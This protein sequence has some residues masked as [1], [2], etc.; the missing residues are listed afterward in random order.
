MSAQGF[1]GSPASVDV[2]RQ[3]NVYFPAGAAADTLIA[4]P[5]TAITADSVV[6]C[7]GAGAVDGTAFVFVVD[8]VNPTVGFSIRSTLAVTAA[9]RVGWAVLKY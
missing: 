6:I 2:P 5:D 4:V 3:G 8:V 7:W 9:K 1:Q